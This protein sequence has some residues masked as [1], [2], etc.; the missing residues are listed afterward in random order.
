MRLASILAKMGREETFSDS[1]WNDIVSMVFDAAV[2]LYQN[3]RIE[4]TPSTSQVH[5]QP[6]T[7]RKGRRRQRNDLIPLGDS[8]HLLGKRQNC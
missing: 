1:D 3:S 5:L 2:W 4:S 7:S 6:K 8:A